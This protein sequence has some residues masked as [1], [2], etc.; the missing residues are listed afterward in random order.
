MMNTAKQTILSDAV[1]TDS[2]PALRQICLITDG[3]S[4]R[5]DLFQ[6]ALSFKHPDLI[7]EA[8]LPEIR[9]TAMMIAAMR[10]DFS[11]VS[12]MVF[13]E[14]ADWFAARIVVLK[15]RV[16][17][18]DVSL[19]PML[20]MANQRAK[21]FAQRHGLSFQAAK[22]RPSL[23]ANRPVNMLLMECDLMPQQSSDLLENCRDV[24]KQSVKFM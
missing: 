24:R 13:T 17:Q 1:A 6:A 3:T 19:K 20:D 10:Y 23:H 8:M 2:T 11:G 5:S 12:P 15:A 14:E 18:L 16:F 21:L 7:S 4:H 9:M 22:I